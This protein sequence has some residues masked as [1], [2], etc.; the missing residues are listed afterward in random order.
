MVFPLVRIAVA[1]VVAVGIGTS[2]W[3]LRNKL[4]GK[5]VA[6]LGRQEVG[7]STLL[8]MLR[9]NKLPDEVTRTTDPIPG[10]EFEMDLGR[11]RKAR[12]NVLKDLPGS[13][14]PTWRVWEEAFT[15]ADIVLYLFRSDKLVE[16]DVAETELVRRHLDML[17][18]W[19]SAVATQKARKIL[20]M[21]IWADQSEFYDVDPSGYL[22]RLRHIPV[23]QKPA[24]KLQANVLCGSLASDDDAKKV[25][26]AMKGYL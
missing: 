20:L 6:I 22:D 8:Y 17:D 16:G 9:D 4:A 21:G 26:K 19:N 3:A 10:G 23:L 14:A 12:F 15:G 18:G 25:I 2:A 24:V 1:V 5:R 11:R 13:A 7:K